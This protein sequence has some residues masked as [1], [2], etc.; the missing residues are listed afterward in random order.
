MLLSTGK[1]LS[2]ALIFA[3]TNPQ[4]DNLLFIDLRVQY[5]IIPSSE[6]EEN[7]LRTCCL[8]VLPLFSPCSELG[9]FKYW[10]YNSMNNL[11]SY[12][13]FVDAKIGASDKDLPVLWTLFSIYLNLGSTSGVYNLKQVWYVYIKGTIFPNS[14]QNLIRKDPSRQSQLTV[15]TLFYWQHI[16]AFQL[17]KRSMIF[18]C[19]EN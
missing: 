15:C 19:E 3:S 18:G 7:I 14:D 16:S 8:L 1:S 12:C 13:G 4:Y 6:H 2:E 5:I 10:T 9:I 17:G 11:S